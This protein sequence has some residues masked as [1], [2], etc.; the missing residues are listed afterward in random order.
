MPVLLLTYE[1]N[2]AVVFDMIEGGVDSWRL[3]V[4]D[5]KL[6]A[7][8]LPC[9]RYDAFYKE[10]NTKGNRLTSFL[11]KLELLAAHFCVCTNTCLTLHLHHIDRNLL[12][13]HAEDFKV[14]NDTLRR[15]KKSTYYFLFFLKKSV[16]YKRFV[17]FLWVPV[18]LWE[19]CQ[20]SHT[21]NPRF[22]A[23]AVY[24]RRHWRDCERGSPDGRASA[25][26]SPWLGC[27]CPRVPRTLW[28]CHQETTR[29]P[30]RCTN[31]NTSIQNAVAF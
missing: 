19:S 5:S 2:L 8:G 4:E 24:S 23:S 14:G 7:I 31:I 28:C 25:S 12:L 6:T 16:T 21:D 13:S 11:W 29:S 30:W 1:L 27:L 18:F 15:Q 17:L 20:L 22:S 26:E 9:K 3:A 10:N